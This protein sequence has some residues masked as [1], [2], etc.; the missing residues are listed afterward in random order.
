MRAIVH[1]SA[2][3]AMSATMFA[4]TATGMGPM[5]KT[6]RPAYD[7]SREVTVTGNVQGFS[8]SSK[9]PSGAHLLITTSNG[10]IDTHVGSFALM[11]GQPLSLRPGERVSVVGVM[12]WVGGSRILLARTVSTSTKSYVIRNQNGALLFPHPTGQVRFKIVTR[13]GE[14][15]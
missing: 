3:L 13:G 1:V 15:Q 7:A 8:V 5:N 14:Q 10:L 6:F 12:T 11:G 9:G 2:V 4:S